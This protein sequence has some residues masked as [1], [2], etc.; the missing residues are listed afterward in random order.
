MIGLFA[1]LMFRSLLAGPGLILAS[2][3]LILGFCGFV[4]CTRCRMRNWGV[5]KRLLRWSGHDKFDDFELMILVHEVIYDRIGTKMTTR[6][7]ITAGAHSVQTDPNSN[8]IFQQPVHLTVEQGTRRL[9]IELLDQKK[10]RALLPLDILSQ[11]LAPEVLKPEMILNMSQ[12]GRA[13][14]NPKIKLSMVVGCHGDEE[15]G[16]LNGAES[17]VDMLV[18]QQ[19]LKAKGEAAP[20]QGHASSEMDVLAQACAGPLEVFE[21]LGQASQIYVNVVGPPISRRYILGLW[22][23]RRDFDAKKKAVEEID[24]LRI[25][26]VQVDPSRHHVFVI[27]YFDDSRVQQTLTFRRIDR[28]RDVWV[29]MLHLLIRKAHADRKAS[30][31]RSSYRHDRRTRGA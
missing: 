25:Q 1:N 26:G 3:T 19:L 12:I 23:D 22:N 24:L 8:G 9:V 20:S 10:V 11:V 15:K 13:L 5:C 18:R 14:K 17:H 2:I 31:R 27:N 6:V 30:K 4:R 29:E 28:A 21:G 16:L 7:R